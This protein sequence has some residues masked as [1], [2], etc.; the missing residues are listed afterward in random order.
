M[1]HKEYRKLHAEW[2]ELVSGGMD[3]SKEIEFW[4]RSIQASSEPV[5]ELG[6]GTGRILVPLLERDF[7]I[8][9]IDTSDDMMARCLAAC[10]VKGLKV[11]LH[12]QSMLELDLSREFGLIIFGSGGLGL[13]TR[14]QD[15]NSLFERVSSHLRPGGTFIYEFEPVPAEEKKN[16]NHNEWTGDWVNGP[17][18]VVIAWRRRNKYNAATHVWERLFVIEKFVGGRLIE[19]EANE[20]WGRHF[21]VDEAVEYAE[22]AGFEDI[23]ATDWLTEDSP[24][25]DSRVLTVRCRKREERT[26]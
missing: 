4:A 25:E 8:V 6:S 11:E 22:S 9:G 15:I 1:E 2:Y 19:T 7:N 13:F 5:L 23:R 14:D 24:R 20:R 21:T 18:D 17:D 12:R 3:H 26:A 10:E 16:R